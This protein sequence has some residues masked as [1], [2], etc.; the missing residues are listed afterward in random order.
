MKSPPPCLWKIFSLS[1]VGGSL[2]RFRGGCRC[3][4]GSSSLP[5][6]EKAKLVRSKLKKTIRSALT[7]PQCVVCTRTRT[8]ARARAHAHAHTHIQSHAH[9]HTQG[10][11]E[12][13][14]HGVLFHLPCAL[15]LSAAINW[16]PLLVDVGRFLVQL[17]LQGKGQAPHQEPEARSTGGAGL[18]AR[19]ISFRRLQHATTHQSDFEPHHI[20]R[21]M[22]LCLMCEREREI[23][24]ERERERERVTHM[25]FPLPCT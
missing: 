8:R 2:R 3:C 5:P 16:C 4:V 11:R 6:V 7:V 19:A 25:Q 17:L 10:N 14:H 18:A 12:G 24:R 13:T 9:T 1:Q 20:V 23:D 15:L 22:R 21:C